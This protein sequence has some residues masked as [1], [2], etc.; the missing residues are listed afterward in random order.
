MVAVAAA[1]LSHC[2]IVV[3]LGGERIKAK[4]DEASFLGVAQYCYQSPVFRLLKMFQFDSHI[5]KPPCM[6]STG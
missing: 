5:L 2:K 3:F 1:G 6:I 4:R